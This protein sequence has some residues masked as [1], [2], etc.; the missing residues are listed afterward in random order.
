MNANRLLVVLWT[1][2]SVERGTLLGKRRGPIFDRLI[3]G[4]TIWTPRQ[5]RKVCDEKQ[6]NIKNPK[7]GMVFTTL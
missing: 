6:N 3:S 7:N 1:K 4:K 2:K 5:I